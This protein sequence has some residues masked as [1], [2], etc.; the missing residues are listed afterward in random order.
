METGKKWFKP[1]NERKSSG[2]IL[3]VPGKN[4]LDRKEQRLSS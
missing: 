2:K 4:L 3:S 1:E